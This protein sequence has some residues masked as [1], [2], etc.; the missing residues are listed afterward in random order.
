M[1][2]DVINDNMSRIIEHYLIGALGEQ[3][4]L[5]EQLPSILENLEENKQAMVDD[6][7]L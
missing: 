4:S 6:M 7:K 2:I 1:V 3:S 5:R